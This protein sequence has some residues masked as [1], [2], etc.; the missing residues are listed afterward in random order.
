MPRTDDD[1][2][3]IAESV[4]ATAV[5]V[6][7]ARAIATKAENAIISDQFAEPLVNAV[8]VEFWSKFAAGEIAISEEDE[9]Q[10][11]SPTVM[12]NSMAVRTRFFDEFFASAGQ[13]GVRQAVILASGL[14]SRAYRLPWP[15]GTTVF[16]LDQP[17]VIEFKTD[18]LAALG[19]EPTAKRVA[20]P[21]DLRHDWPKALVEAGF[22]P[23][24][25]SSWS[26]EGLTPYLPAEAELLLYERIDE[27]SAPGSWVAV[28]YIEHLHELP[29]DRFQAAAKRFAELGLDLD[30]SNLFYRDEE[31]GDTTEWFAERGWA[32][33][34]VTSSQLLAQADLPIPDHQRQ[35][36][37]TIYLTSRKE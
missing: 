14:D 22:D 29:T 32:T 28:E 4:G 7:A 26:V 5:M 8:G 35:I 37:N 20:I 18:T 15:E 24:S 19:A 9:R 2:W 1:T 33:E 30:M 27:L 31:R 10:F 34:T 11:G 25:P 36:S 16:E 23:K 6:A 3:S 21:V 17:Q 13:S 12:A